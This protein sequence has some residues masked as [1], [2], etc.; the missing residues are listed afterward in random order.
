MIVSYIC[1]L[2]L[3]SDRSA[4]GS[5]AEEKIAGP[6]DEAA[7]LEARRKRREAIRAKYRGQTPLLVKA[8]HQGADTELLTPS[9]TPLEASA[10]GQYHR[11]TGDKTFAHC[12]RFTNVSCARSAH[13]SHWSF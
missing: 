13:R 10:P 5:A 4:N 9:D 3:I 6:V 1:E 2:W 7:Q 12:R 8:L 11:T